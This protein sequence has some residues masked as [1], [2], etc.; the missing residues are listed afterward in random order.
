MHPHPDD[1]VLDGLALVTCA[2]TG[3]WDGAQVILRN[4]DPVAVCGFLARLGADLIQVYVDEE[5]EFLSR[6]RAH[7]TSP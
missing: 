1:A 4:A 6:M 2:H 5:P 3:D 7:Y